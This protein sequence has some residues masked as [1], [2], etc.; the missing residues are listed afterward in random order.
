MQQHGS[1]YF[2]FRSSPSNSHPRQNVNFSEHGHV[3]YHT[4]HN[5]KIYDIFFCF[6]NDG[7]VAQEFTALHVARPELFYKLIYGIFF[8]RFS[9]GG[10]EKK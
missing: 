9:V 4:Y 6:Q 2:A 7:L 3:A 8:F 5:G 1:K 10:D